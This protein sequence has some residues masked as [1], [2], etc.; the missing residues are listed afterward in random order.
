MIVDTFG[1]ADEDRFWDIKEFE[2]GRCV[3]RS[4]EF[5]RQYYRKIGYYDELM[6][7]REG[8]EAEP[9]IPSLP[10]EIIQQISQIYIDLFEDLTGQRF[11]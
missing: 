2:D 6:K 4:K 9:P 1:T 11:R 8:G 3:E 10:N 5:V 7:A